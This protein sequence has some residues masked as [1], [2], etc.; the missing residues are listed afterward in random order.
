M[1]TVPDYSTMKS[2]VL[3]IRD[4]NATAWKLAE[5]WCR[6]GRNHAKK[7]EKTLADNLSEISQLLAEADKEVGK[8]VP[9]A[10]IIIELQREL[11]EAKRRK[12]KKDE[13]ELIKKLNISDKAAKKHQLTINDLFKKIVPIRDN[14]KELVEAIKNI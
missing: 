1:A 13:R 9:H 3:S 14:T 10:E 7:L 8:W 4:H 11:K 12:N 6:L 5:K 2:K